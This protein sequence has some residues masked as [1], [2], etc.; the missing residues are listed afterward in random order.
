MVDPASHQAINGFLN[1]CNQKGINISLSKQVLC[2]CLHL[3]VAGDVPA[4]SHLW[5]ALAG[6]SSK[7]RAVALFPWQ[8]MGSQGSTPLD[9]I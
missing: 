2:I 4:S 3:D 1:L 6:R 8:H 5:L 7:L 9:I